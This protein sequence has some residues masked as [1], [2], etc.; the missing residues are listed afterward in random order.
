MKK[1]ILSVVLAIVSFAAN[2]G[3]YSEG[4]RVGEVQKF[5]EKGFVVKSWEGEMVQEGIRGKGASGDR[6]L[7]NI[8]KFSVDDATVAKKMNDALFE[9]GPVTV[10]YC[11]KFFNTG[12]TSSTGYIVTDVRV[13]K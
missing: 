11:K 10:K 8:W 4:I 5:S 6:T 2:A 9:G 3:C 7:T 13:K 12:L 1:I